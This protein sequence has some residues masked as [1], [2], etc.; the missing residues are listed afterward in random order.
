MNPF[1]LL[2]PLW[3]FPTLYLVFLATFALLFDLLLF[4]ELLRDAGFAEGLAFAA[5]VGLSVKGGLQRR[6]TPHANHHLL[7]QLQAEKVRS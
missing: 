5:L 4:L 6:V 2:E 7:T 3:C 1:A